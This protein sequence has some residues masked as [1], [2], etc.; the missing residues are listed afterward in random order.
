MPFSRT[1]VAG[2]PGRLWG[3]EPAHDH[4][5]GLAVGVASRQSE[6]VLE[7][8]REGDCLVVRMDITTA[9][10]LWEAL[11]V[12]GEHEAAGAPI[13][14]ASREAEERLGEVLRDLDIALGGTGRLA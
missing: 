1:L 7:I 2:P 3:A 10:D 14:K 12:L 5:I 13:P 8:T 6:L 9:R 4:L 11:Y